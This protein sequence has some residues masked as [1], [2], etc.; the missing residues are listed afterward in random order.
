MQI[1]Y[2]SAVLPQTDSAKILFEMSAGILHGGDSLRTYL[3]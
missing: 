3:R 1:K 2:R